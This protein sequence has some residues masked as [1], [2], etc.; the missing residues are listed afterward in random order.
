MRNSWRK[1]RQK[2]PGKKRATRPTVLTLL[3]H[4]LTSA[5][6]GGMFLILAFGGALIVF[7]YYNNFQPENFLA[8]LLGFIV[9]M[10]FYRGCVA[11]QHDLDEY[12]RRLSGLRHSHDLKNLNSN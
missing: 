7:L 2:N 5:F 10:A 12:R 3:K 8:L 9:V 1:P 11:W 6:T 4:I